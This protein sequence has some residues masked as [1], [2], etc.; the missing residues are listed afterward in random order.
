[1]SLSAGWWGS[2]TNAA[3]AR[4]CASRRPTLRSAKAEPEAMPTG[5]KK[6]PDPLSPFKRALS[7]ATRTLAENKSVNVV[8]GTDTPGF[9][10]K[11]IRL[12]QPGRVVSRKEIAV[13]RGFADSI[14][15]LISHHDTALHAA[16]SPPSG[17]AKAV[18]DSVERARVEALGALR[19]RGVAK[20]LT[21]KLAS[22][23]ERLPDRDIDRQSAPLEDALALMIRERLTGA[24]PPRGANGIVEVWW[25]WVEERAGPL[26]ERLEGAVDDQAAFSKLMRDILI[27]LELME[28]TPESAQDEAGGEANEN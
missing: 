6:K 22:Q 13:I 28:G 21:A 2:S 23:Y 15:L 27:A 18:F 14:A 12:P 17:E 24:K 7:L 11:T 1:M 19:M 10:G 8:F 3:S 4:N 20:N 9:D 5:A 26:M 25:P 16:L